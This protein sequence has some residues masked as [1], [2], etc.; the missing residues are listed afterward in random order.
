M[1]IDLHVHASE[2]SECAVA[3][4][5]EMIRAA[6]RA[7][8]DA[9]VF[10]DHH[11]LVG[12]RRLEQLNR[13]YAP[14]RIYGGIEITADSEDWLVYGVQAPELESTAWSYPGLA[15]FV[16]ERGGFI[17]LA[18][19]FRYE[20][21]I[22]VD[23]AGCPPDAIEVS[24]LN[25]PPEREGEIRRIAAQLGLALLSNS[26]AHSPAPLGRYYNEIALTLDGDRG[27]VERLRA[28][29]G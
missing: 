28:L 14:F 7:G 17:A 13:L 23:L 6:V 11:L 27:L 1:K 26:D 29:K 9:L 20:P 25:T 15:A 2:R 4:E 5:E 16:R 21:R 8:L 24:S 12:A 18:H 10:T 3:G 19:P 22:H